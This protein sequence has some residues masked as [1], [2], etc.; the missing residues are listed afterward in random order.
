MYI[1]HR[2]KIGPVEG[3][4]CRTE[5]PVQAG[6]VQPPISAPPVVPA[7]VPHSRL[8]PITRTTGYRSSQVPRLR[9]SSEVKDVKLDDNK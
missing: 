2:L 8:R 4:R 1:K 9:R 3:A 6:A 7:A 5:C